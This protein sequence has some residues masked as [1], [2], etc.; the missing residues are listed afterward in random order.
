MSIPLL[1]LGGLAIRTIAKPVSKRLKIEAGRQQGLKSACITV[2]QWSHQ[3]TSFI[4]ITAAGH[5][6]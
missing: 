1:K 6:R 4:N 5:R 3:F 2:G